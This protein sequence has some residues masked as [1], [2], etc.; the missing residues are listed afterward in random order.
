MNNYSKSLL[1]ISALVIGMSSGVS[2]VFAVYDDTWQIAQSGS[3]RYIVSES[4]ANDTYIIFQESHDNGMN[5][6]NPV[7]LSAFIQSPQIVT[8]SNKPLIGA[9]GD[10]VYIYW[11]STFA[12]GVKNLFYIDSKDGGFTFGN[13]TNVSLMEG[14]EGQSVISAKL[15]VDPISGTVYAAFKLSDNTIVPCRVHCD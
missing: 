12:S 5:F 14:H 8:S 3:H 15:D 7:N 10:N 11:L 4:S 1:V 6:S 2:A 9:F 13:A